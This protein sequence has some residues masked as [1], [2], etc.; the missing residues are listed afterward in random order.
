MQ[1]GLARYINHSCEPNCY[2][3]ITEV[4]GRK[5][6]VINAKRRI[7]PG[8]ELCY[9]Y[10]VRA[11]AVDMLDHAHVCCCAAQFEF[12]DESMKIPCMCGAKNCRKFMN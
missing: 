3:R 9:D 11:C 2:T 6:I 8:E 10:K 1:G 5:H 12:E 4:A 7:E